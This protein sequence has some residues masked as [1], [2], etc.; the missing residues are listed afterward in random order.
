[1]R[2]RILLVT[3]VLLVSGI[4]LSEEP[5]AFEDYLHRV[6]MVELLAN[7]ARFNGKVITV[8]GFLRLEF[9]GNALY[10]HQEDFEQS[11]TENAIWIDPGEISSDKAKAVSDQ[12]VLLVGKFD[13][14]ERGH[15]GLFGGTIGSIKRLERWPSRAEF[16]KLSG[17]VPSEK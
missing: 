14:R 13:A 2:A 16:E 15:M 7:R 3:A 5:P 9:E 1:M 8:K 6:S 12:Y 11:L 4:V 17:H 10:L